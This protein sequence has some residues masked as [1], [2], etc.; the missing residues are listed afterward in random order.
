MNTGD[1]LRLV[2]DYLASLP[3]HTFDVLSL[4]KPITVNAAVNLAKVI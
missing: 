1:V 4:S 3:G 2:S